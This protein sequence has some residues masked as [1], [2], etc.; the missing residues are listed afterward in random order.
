MAAG[1]RR[2]AL[3]VIVFL[4]AIFLSAAVSRGAETRSSGYLVGRVGDISQTAFE[5]TP[6]FAG[7]NVPVRLYFSNEALAPFFSLYS[8]SRN[9]NGGGFVGLTKRATFYLSTEG[10][11]EDVSFE[12]HTIWVEIGGIENRTVRFFPVPGEFYFR[13]RD[14]P[15]S[16]VA[17]KAIR[18]TVVELPS[19]GRKLPVEVSV[20]VW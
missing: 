14:V 15:P 7:E 11:P 5:V 20:L 19:A 1:E 12:N 6:S 3:F 8:D 17:T 18:Q 9:W 10:I 2:P 13:G 16:V 4:L